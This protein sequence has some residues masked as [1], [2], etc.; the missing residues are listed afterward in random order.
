M[1]TNMLAYEE[2]MA[3]R[4]LGQPK[5]PANISLKVQLVRFTPFIPNELT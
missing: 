4:S 2:G 5:Y 3:K 1:L